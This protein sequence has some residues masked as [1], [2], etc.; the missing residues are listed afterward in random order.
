MGSWSAR[1]LVYGW[2]AE[3]GARRAFGG[4]GGVPGVPE[5]GSTCKNAHID[6]DGRAHATFAMPHMRSA[7][8]LEILRRDAGFDRSTGPPWS[9]CSA[10]QATRQPKPRQHRVTTARSQNSLVLR[11][12]RAWV[13]CGAGCPAC[14]GG[15]VRRVKP[16]FSS[17]IR[18]PCITLHGIRALSLHGSAIRAEKAHLCMP[19][20]LPRPLP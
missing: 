20:L 8:R 10:N 6:P 1:R 18:E 13:V 12:D 11:G 16:R 17:R 3:R 14:L 2:Y 5:G 4:R 15:A 7:S 9:P 19:R